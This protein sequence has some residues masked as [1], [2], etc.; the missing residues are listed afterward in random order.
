MPVTE[1]SN[2]AIEKYLDALT[3]L[4]EVERRHGFSDADRSKKVLKEQ[5]KTWKGNLETGRRTLRI[6]SELIAK[7]KT[8][9]ELQDTFMDHRIDGQWTGAFEFGE[10]LL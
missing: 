3:L 1:A 5:I 10:Y 2:T 6:A 8:K 9:E 4:L 7:A